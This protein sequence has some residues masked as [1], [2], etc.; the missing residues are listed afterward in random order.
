MLI[1]VSKTVFVSVYTPPVA[2]HF[3]V[4]AQLV[5]S[6]L[7]S[8]HAGGGLRK[9]RRKEGVL[10]EREHDKQAQPPDLNTTFIS[11]EAVGTVNFK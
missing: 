6:D 5:S 9:R 11:Q 2:M 1:L 10:R 3:S 8:C 4:S 7:H